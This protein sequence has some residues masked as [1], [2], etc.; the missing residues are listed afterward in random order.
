[1]SGSPVTATVQAQGMPHDASQRTINP[2][3][4]SHASERSASRRRQQGSA[5]ATPTTTA[6]APS[7]TVSPADLAVSDPSNGHSRAASMPYQPAP[8]QLQDQPTQSNQPTVAHTAQAHSNGQAV[9]YATQSQQREPYYASTS[10]PYH[11]PYPSAVQYAHPQAAL[12]SNVAPATVPVTS[13]VPSGVP[14][15]VMQHMPSASSSTDSP[16][17][18]HAHG[19]YPHSGSAYQPYYPQPGHSHESTGYRSHQSGQAALPY[20]PGLRSASMGGMSLQAQQQAATAHY[21]GY[22]VQP[23]PSGASP[24]YEGGHRKSLSTATY[25]SYAGNTGHAPPLLASGTLADRAMPPAED[26]GNMSISQSMQSGPLYTSYGSGEL[27]SSGPGSPGRYSQAMLPGG[28]HPSMGYS[29]GAQLSPNAM[30][31]PYYTPHPSPG[32]HSPRTVYVGA[33]PSDAAVDELL[34]QV[35]FGPIESVR[36]LPEK[37]CAFISF[38][39]SHTASAFH[40]DAQMRRIQLHGT[41]L[42]IG[43]GKPTSVPNNVYQAASR[44]NAT[45]NVY[46]GHLGDDVTE[47]SLYDELSDFGPI[48]QVKIV[49]DRNIGFVHFLSIATAMQ[50]VETLSEDKEWSGKR[51]SYGKDRCAYVPKNQQQQQA[52]NMQAAALAASAAGYAYNA[53]MMYDA[54]AGN[55]TVYLGNIHPDSTT[56]EICNTVRGGILQQIRYLP[57]KHIAFVTFV[58]AN[59]AF[60]FFNASNYSGILL[61]NRRLKVGWGKHSGPCSPGISMAVQAGASRNLYIGNIDNFDEVTEEKLRHDFGVHGEIEQVNFVREKNCAFVNYTNIQASIKALDLMKAHPN[62]AALKISFGKDRCGNPARTAPMRPRPVVAEE[63]GSSAIPEVRTGADLS[64]SATSSKG[65]ET[66]TP[67]TESE[68]PIETKQ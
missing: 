50:V 34:S 39:D 2:G 44:H 18:H 37:S 65:D 63:R 5:Q 7:P 56:E 26:F 38:L 57:D 32:Q 58:D 33:L 53:N 16:Y 15:P 29:Y 3:Q 27:S 52:H 1:M 59:A 30:N 36:I 51:V 35:R 55:R 20:S 23:I 24:S 13:T 43:W 12:P 46:I 4:S 22:P 54:N 48:D 10:E 28:G 21:A 25:P 60:A 14:A 67:T 41:E 45:R 11:Q 62:Y 19:H 17:D 9:H 47:Q 66:Q 49:R 68:S 8:R 42:K 31:F 64:Q 40:S 61:H 6:A